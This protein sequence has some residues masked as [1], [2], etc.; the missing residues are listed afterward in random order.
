MPSSYSQDWK[1]FIFRAMDDTKRTNNRIDALDQIIKEKLDDIHQS[2][3]QKLDARSQSTNQKVDALNRKMEEKIMNQGNL[4]SREL[5]NQLTSQLQA[6]I[7]QLREDADNGQKQIK[8]LLD[9]VE[10]LKAAFQEGRHASMEQGLEFDHLK[11][12]VEIDH[13]TLFDLAGEIE[14]VKMGGTSELSRVNN[15]IA[16]KAGKREVERQLRALRAGGTEPNAMKQPRQGTMVDP[17]I[18]AVRI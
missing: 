18:A 4:A 2:I 8:S 5:V 7:V 16:M 17:I 14:Q 3:N 13:A 6:A 1:F 12:A 9:T 15:E 10:Q 11:A